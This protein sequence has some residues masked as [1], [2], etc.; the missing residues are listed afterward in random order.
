[1]LQ[2]SGAKRVNGAATVAGL[3]SIGTG[4]TVN[5]LEDANTGDLVKSVE[6]HDFQLLSLGTADKN[7]LPPQPRKSN[8]PQRLWKQGS[9]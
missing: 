5:K 1:M 2:L 3:V 7:I 9:Q 8:T 6:R 4:L